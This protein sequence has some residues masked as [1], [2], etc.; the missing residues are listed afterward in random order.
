M[1]S[2]FF[3]LI[4]LVILIS[5]SLP[6]TAK[7]GVGMRN[8]AKATEA[9][10]LSARGL[11]Y[12]PNVVNSSAMVTGKGTL[13]GKSVAIDAKALQTKLERVVRSA[14]QQKA[15][16]RTQILTG[17]ALSKVAMPSA[18]V[19]Q[20]ASEKNGN[21]P[22]KL[23]RTLVLIKPDAIEQ[24]ISGVILDRLDK[25]GL[26]LI[27]AKVVSATEEMIRTHYK[28]LAGTSFV[29]GVVDYMLGKYNNVPNHKIYAFV[30]QGE[31]AI[32][33]VRAEI[34][35]TNPEKADPNTIRGSYGRTVNG[36]IQNCVHAS[37]APDE[38]EEE[39]ALWFNPGEVLDF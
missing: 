37:G 22:A 39:I 14:K 28:H 2:F 11:R 31:D 25:L 9:A 1:K 23:Q 6:A 5:G 19:P 27:G 24:R 4:S 20:G 3:S 12:V 36:V 32:A 21:E 10:K 13:P 35:S 26:Q 29:D 30:F 33:K 18:K 15:S 16:A 38:A 34:G 17:A 8:A 7:I